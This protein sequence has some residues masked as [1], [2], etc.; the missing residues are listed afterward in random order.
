MRDGLFRS[1]ETLYDF[2]LI[3]NKRAVSTF[4]QMAAGEQMSL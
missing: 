2:V 4:D 3:G 1:V